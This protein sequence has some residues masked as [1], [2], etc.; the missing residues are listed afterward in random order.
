[1]K[2]IRARID[3][4][5]SITSDR[6][7]GNEVF[8][9]GEHVFLQMEIR[10][11]FISLDLWLIDELIEEARASGIARAHPFLGEDAVKV[12]F[13]RAADLARVARWIEASYAYAP[14]REERRAVLAVERAKNEAIRAA[15]E[16]A[17]RIAREEAERIALAEAARQAKEDAERARLAAEMSLRLFAT[18]PP[19]LKK[20]N[21]V[22]KTGAVPAPTSKG[23]ASE[24]AKGA[25]PVAAAKASKPGPAA[26]TAKPAPAAKAAKHAPAAKATKPAPAAKPAKP[27]KPAAAAKAAKPLKSA[28]PTK[29]AKPVKVSKASRPTTSASAKKPS[30]KR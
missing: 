10:R 16:E 21:G 12:R 15:Q 28:K 23:A 26:K 22:A 14:N 13:E 9:R 19:A 11:D 30:K 7:S 4:L 20:A 2:A 17:D 5:P 29:A 8:Q 25:K 3:T 27:A 6:R 24:K 1:M 18:P